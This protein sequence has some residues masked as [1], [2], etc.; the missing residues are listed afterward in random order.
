[1]EA[2]AETPDLDEGAFRRASD[3][4]VLQ[5]LASD[6]IETRACKPVGAKQRFGD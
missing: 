5:A 1:M 4:A 2:V 6:D 3:A